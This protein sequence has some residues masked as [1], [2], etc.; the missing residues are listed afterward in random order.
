MSYTLA[1]I[2]TGYVGLVTAA[3][4]SELGCKVHCVD[5]NKAKIKD[6]KKGIIP[7]YEPGL[8]EL[9]AKNRKHKKLDF[10][11]SIKDAVNKAYLAV[12]KIKFEG[13]HFRSDIGAKA[14]K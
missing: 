7:I 10:G 12:D 9:V 5:S 4:F 2:G 8:T 3:C 14:T 1:V 11:T 13:M 6:I